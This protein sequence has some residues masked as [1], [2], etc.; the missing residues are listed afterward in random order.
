MKTKNSKVNMDLTSEMKSVLQE[1]ETACKYIEGE[2]YEMTITSA[3]DGVHM[4][5]SLHYS[6]NAIDIRS[7][8][9]RNPNTTKNTI[10]TALGAKFDVIYEIDHIHIEYDPK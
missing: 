5:N 7:R 9:M 2:A 8:D 3:K 1:I 4:K 10:K 6:G